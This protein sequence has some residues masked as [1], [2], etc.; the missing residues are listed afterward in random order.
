MESVSALGTPQ[1]A[2]YPEELISD[3]KYASH[4]EYTV[5]T[6]ASTILSLVMHN[7]ATEKTTTSRVEREKRRR[8]ESRAMPYNVGVHE[9]M[10]F[11]LRLAGRRSGA[12]SFTILLMCSGSQDVCR[13]MFLLESTA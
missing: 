13:E 1:V 12:Y 10:N 7:A 2:L 5:L 6:P 9:M 11:G 3:M 4:L 8:S